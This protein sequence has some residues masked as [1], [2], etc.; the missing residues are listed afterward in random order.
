MNSERGIALILVLVMLPLVAIIMTQLH[1]ETSIGQHLANNILANQ[2]FKHAIMARVRQMRV[3]LV[4]DLKED[5]QQAQQQGASDHYSDAWGPDTEGG[6]TALMVKKGSE[7]AGDDITLYTQVIDEL[8]KFNLN[9]LRHTD[10]N[11]RGRAERVFRN[12]LDFYRD[13][14]FGDLRENEWDLDEAEAAQVLEAVKKFLKGEGRDQRVQQAE[15][16]N[17]S[18]D[19]RQGLYD[20]ADL[21]FCDRIF[22]EKRLLERFTDLESNQVIPSLADFITVFGEGKINANTASIQVLRSQFTEDPGHRDAAEGIF[23]GRGGFL[24]TEQD[25]EERTAK[26]DERERLSQE[27]DEEGLAE[28]DTGFTSIDDIGKSHDLLR[29][30]GF[31]RRNGLELGRDFAVRSDFFRIIVTARRGRFVRQ[32]IVVIQRHPA[33]SLTWST[34][35]RAADVSDLPEAASEEEAE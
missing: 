14:R 13:S 11:R 26:D 12:L 2:Q 15:L 10:K 24:D 23:H 34:E 1:Y 25:D 22:L 28:L 5:E 19:L 32:Q 27:G 17:P 6:E 21:I 18:Q 35:V 20:V 3:R 7:E 9:L 8:G 31:M 33:G 16:P 29:E 4:R 30:S